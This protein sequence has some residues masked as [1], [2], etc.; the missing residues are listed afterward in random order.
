MRVLP[1][2]RSHDPGLAALRRAGRSAIVM[3]ALFALGVKVIG[4]AQVAT[5]AAFGSLSLLLFVGFSGP[6]R[7]RLQA[8]LALS[9]TGAAFVCVGTLASRTAWLA[10][11][12]MAVVGFCVLFAG[13]VS[14]VLAA[15]TPS[16]LL[17][18]ILPV[19]LAGP[20]SAIPDRLAG[21]ALAS[22][23][24][25]AAIALLWPA[26]ASDPL[27]LRAA[28]AC[29][30]LADR[31]RSEVARVIG[32]DDAP[33][34]ASHARV[35][36]QASEAVRAMHQGFLATPYRPTGLSTSGRTV[37]RL[38]DELNWLNSVIESGPP[39]GGLPANR[40]ACAVKSA[41]ANVLAAGAGLLGEFGGAADAL[42]AA[43]AVLRSAVEHLEAET[44]VVA[45]DRPRAALPTGVEPQEQARALVSALDPAFRAQELAFAVSQIAANVQLAAAAERRSWLDRV[46]GRQ[47]AG[48]VSA[49]TAAQERAAAHFNASSVWMHNSLRG[50]AGLGLAVLVADLTGV[51]HSF[52]VVL[53]TL[54]VL[55][56]NA[57]NT[58]QN[59]LRGLLGTAAGFVVGAA[60]LV[61]IG[62]NT[63]VLWVLLPVAILLAGVLPAAISFA[64]GQAAF[65]VTLVILFNIIAPS[66]WQIGL[67]R[68]EDIAIGCAVSLVV[69]VLFWPRGAGAA[70]GRALGQAYED[71]A[72]YLADAVGFGMHRCDARPLS[73]PAPSDPAPARLRA[74]AASRRLDDAF[75]TY[76]AERGAKPMALADVTN[77][78]TGVGGLRLAGDA[79]LDL[80][81]RDGGTVAGDRAAARREILG[82]TQAV[83]DWYGV[84]AASLRAGVAAPRPQRRGLRPDDGLVDALHRDLLGEDGRATLTAARMVWTGDYVDSVRR[85]Q[86]ALV[87][88]VRTA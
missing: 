47:P 59:V 84:L 63:A 51:Q 35:V 57:L 4:N 19:S 7:E 69:G 46:L 62:T 36:Q 44:D 9:L 5:F 34:E 85:M 3:P 43:L 26:P 71:S 2:L 75:R 66:G 54:S 65:T 48:V 52:W 25:L 21:W 40:A 24:S 42:D 77:L 81:Q 1:W 39:P 10:A 30:A 86:D 38:V 41:S 27:R 49:V 83:V 18:F 22:V 23:V 37:V 12:S 55:R 13:V 67:L 50:A 64:A 20:P 31:L 73:V 70:L 68:I 17:A 72:Q 88:T 32:G 58:G 74:A 87:D 53:G 79:V 16:L 14:S 45:P 78:V 80:W 6:M 76:L 56:S 15:A 29:R 61:P 82:T 33:T 11:V 60:L 8:Q 28:V